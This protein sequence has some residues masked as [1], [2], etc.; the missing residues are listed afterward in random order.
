MIAELDDG[1]V[2]RAGAIES[3]WRRIAKLH[4]RVHQA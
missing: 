3:A 2:W 4:A 1:D